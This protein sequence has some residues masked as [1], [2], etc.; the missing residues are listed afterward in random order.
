MFSNLEQA[1]RN[2]DEARAV[3]LANDILTHYKVRQ[4]TG[5]NTMA[6]IIYAL[7]LKK[8]NRAA[9]NMTGNQLWQNIKD[10]APPRSRL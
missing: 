10:P 4:Y 2:R 1:I 5:N 6:R 9:H 3:K 7:R 8:Y